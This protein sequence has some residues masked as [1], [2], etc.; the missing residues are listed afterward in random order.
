MSAGDRGRGP[1]PLERAAQAVGEPGA[2][3]PSELVAGPGDVEAA[4]LDLSIAGRGEPR[5]ERAFGVRS[6]RRDDVPDGCR[7]PGADV[8]LAARRRLGQECEQGLDDVGNVDVVSR[9]VA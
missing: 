8:E 7:P 2:G 4:V 9:L 5:L 1:R 3:G 6:E